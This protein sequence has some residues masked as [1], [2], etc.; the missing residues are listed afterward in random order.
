MTKR[1]CVEIIGSNF[2]KL[3]LLIFYIYIYRNDYEPNLPL[4]SG[5]VSVKNTTTTLVVNM[6]RLSSPI[7]M[8]VLYKYHN[9]YHGKYIIFANHILCFD[10]C[11]SL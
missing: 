4:K 7:A 6:H 8:L 10:L 2:F 9:T 3:L 1:K 5:N 11:M